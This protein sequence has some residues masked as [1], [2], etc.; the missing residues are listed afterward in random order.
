MPPRRRILPPLKIRARD[1]I[2]PHSGTQARDKARR[3]CRRKILPLLKHCKIWPH[4][5]ALASGRAPLRLSPKARRKIPQPHK[6]GKIPPLCRKKFCSNTSAPIRP[7]R[8]ISG[9]CAAPFTAI[10]SRASET[11]LGTASIPST[12]STT[13]AIRSSFWALRSRFV[14]ASSRART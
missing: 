3:L 9:T 6:H 8:F 1:R 12:T 5:I 10:R 13:R 4:F 14:R 2:P 11:I 7:V